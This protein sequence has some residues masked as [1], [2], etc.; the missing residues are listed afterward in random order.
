MHS[1]R[2]KLIAK[3]VAVFCVTVMVAASG[4]A[5]EVTD[6]NHN[7]LRDAAVENSESISR[8]IEWGQTVADAIWNWRSTDGLA[9][10]PP[11]FFGGSDVGQWRPTPPGFLAGAVPQFGGLTPWVLLFQSQFRPDGP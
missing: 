9:P 6:W 8:G 4:V 3:G 11:P 10:P 2:G 1:Q 5:D 7:M